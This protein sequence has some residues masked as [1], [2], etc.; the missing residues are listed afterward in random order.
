[1]WPL[2]LQVSGEAEPTKGLQDISRSI[3]AVQEK[4]VALEEELDG[5]ERV[6]V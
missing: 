6:S 2:L 4:I 1:M 3:E 5:I